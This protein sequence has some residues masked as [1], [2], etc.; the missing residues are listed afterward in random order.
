M[1]RIERVDDPIAIH[2]HEARLVLFEAVG[3]GVAGRVEP[4]AAPALA[5]VGRSEAA[6]RSRCRY[7]GSPA[8][9]F[10]R[11]QLLERRRQADQIER[12]PA[13]QRVRARRRR[14]LRALPAPA[15]RARTH[16]SDCEPSLRSSPAG[17]AG[18]CGATNAQCCLYVAPCAIHF[19]S[20][21]ICSGVSVLPESAGGMRTSGSSLVMR[22]I[23][24]L[25]SGLPG[26]DHGFGAANVAGIL[27]HIEP[28]IGLPLGRIRPVAVEAV[29]R[30]NRPHIAREID[31]RIAVASRRRACA[32][33]P[34]R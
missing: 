17:T 10:E 28:Q 3:V 19:R 14:R 30:Q 29:V 33:S 8:G 25:S 13:Q 5:V 9:C 11:G 31:R 2:P 24:S 4:D 7:A 6:A 15:A 21:S 18:R 32:A 1:S 16:R 12:Q 23:S 34:R 22:A 20:V 26:D 27:P